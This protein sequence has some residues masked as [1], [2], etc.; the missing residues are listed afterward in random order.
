MFSILQAAET[1]TKA[2]A[3]A[4]GSSLQATLM[5]LLPL[6]L[7]FVIFYFLLIRPQ[8]K[9]QQNQANMIANIKSGDAV[10]LNSGIKG[11]VTGVKDTVFVIEIANNTEIEV[12]KS[13]IAQVETK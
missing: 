11:K 10:I 5:N 9:R 7:I 4:G 1:T 12:V 13:H 8:R 2:T 6:V 3:Q